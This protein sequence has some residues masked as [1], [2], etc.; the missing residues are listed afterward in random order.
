MATSSVVNRRRANSLGSGSWLDS[1]SSETNR[2]D[3]ND[4][5][6][7]LYW[8][9]SNISYL[10]AIQCRCVFAPRAET[11]PKL[12]D[13]NQTYHLEKARTPSQPSDGSYYQALPMQHFSCAGTHQSVLGRGR[14]PSH[15]SPLSVKQQLELCEVLV[16]GYSTASDEETSM[17]LASDC[18]VSRRNDS[19]C[20][21][22]EKGPVK[23]LPPRL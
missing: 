5:R 14:A 7:L 6:K 8:M 16:L 17:M 13:E 12:V 9:T 2:R 4:F 18:G 21:G 11:Y 22:R 1:P 10:L 23:V 20:G 3:L 15:S 19:T